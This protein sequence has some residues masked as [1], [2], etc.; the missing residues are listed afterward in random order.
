[1]EE[2]ITLREYLLHYTE[3]GDFIAFTEGGWQIGCT[4]I[5]H[6]D[7]FIKSLNP[8]MLEKPVICTKKENNERFGKTTV[9]ELYR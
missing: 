7:L 2:K 9:I 6:E 1:M 3:V 4:F 5:D 8:H